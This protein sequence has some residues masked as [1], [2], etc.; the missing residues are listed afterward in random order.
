MPVGL[1]KELGSSSTGSGNS[2]MGALKGSGGLN[3]NSGSLGTAGSGSNNQPVGA[4]QNASQLDMSLN[5]LFDQL[6][7]VNG[8]LIHNSNFDLSQKLNEELL[9]RSML[10][11]GNSSGEQAT[12]IHNQDAIGEVVIGQHQYECEPVVPRQPIL[13]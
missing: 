11:G 5:N 7:M 13:V 6:R 12:G 3:A 2:G 1:A 10:G 9:L 4:H 8:P